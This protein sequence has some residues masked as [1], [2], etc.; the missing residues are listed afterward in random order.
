M[1]LKCTGFIY[2]KELKHLNVKNLD[3]STTKLWSMNKF[4]FG[5]I[6]CETALNL[7]QHQMDWKNQIGNGNTVISV[8]LYLK[9]AYLRSKQIVT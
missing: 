1:H 7:I 8:F 5:K 4:V 9:R 2:T 6:T 3:R